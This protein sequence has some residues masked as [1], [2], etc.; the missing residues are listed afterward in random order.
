MGEARLMDRVDTKF[1]TTEDSLAALL[2]EAESAYFAQDIDGRRIASYY[3]LYYDTEDCSM[4]LAHHNGKL[5]R[6]KLRIR[7]Y[8]DSSLDFLEVKT[9]DN[10]GRTR[11]NR[12]VIYNFDHTRHVEADVCKTCSDT[13]RDCRA[14]LADHLRYDPL[15]MRRKIENRFRR[16]TLVD[17]GK[18]ERVTID[19]GIRFYNYVTGVSLSLP[20]L[21]VIELKRTRGS[22]SPILS[23]LRR[24]HIKPM[25][26]SKYC[27]GMSMTD[28][29]LKKNLFLPRIHKTNKMT[30]Y[31][32]NDGRA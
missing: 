27:I 3:T 13:S 21:V 6:Q 30:A 32:Q 31:K 17:K 16:I 8:I 4:F 26:F 19:T 22:R 2:A 28:A 7:S 11:K 10:H 14:F 25:G 24:L 18:T 29:R 20:R 9:K 15:A 5:N 12:I 23:A 1:V